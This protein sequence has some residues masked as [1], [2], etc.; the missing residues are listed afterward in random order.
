MAQ[1]LKDKEQLRATL[2]NKVIT[3]QEEERKRISREL[4][5]ETGQALTS[6]IV[7]MRVLANKASDE[8]QRELLLSARDVAA[9]VLLDIRNMAVELR[10]TALDDL[11]LAAAVR[12][13]VA[14]FQE[15]FGILIEFTVDSAINELD[16]DLSVTLYRIVQESLVNAAR[17]SGATAM[18]ISLS[19][20]PGRVNLR[21]SDNGQGMA[22]GELE[23][24]ARENR[25]GIYGM[26]ERVELCGGE[27]RLESIVG[28]GTTILVS[29]PTT[30][31]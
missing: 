9:G 20:S 17:H 5:D 14:N 26:R 19:M 25:L 7:S 30:H 8:R 27:F 22:E 24:A 16:G 4:H 18:D 11:G 12:K 3:A 21:I 29:I 10:P 6:L 1:E 23:K 13:Y 2:L 28:T 15:R 31:S